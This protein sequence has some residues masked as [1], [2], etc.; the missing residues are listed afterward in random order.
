MAQDALKSGMVHVLVLDVLRDVAPV[1]AL[2]E[3][4]PTLPMVRF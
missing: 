4:L 1:S 2:V 3:T